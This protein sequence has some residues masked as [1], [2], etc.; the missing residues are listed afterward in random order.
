MKEAV[1]VEI[2]IAHFS[3]IE[4]VSCITPKKEQKVT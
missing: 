4:N 3:S 2:L 1:T